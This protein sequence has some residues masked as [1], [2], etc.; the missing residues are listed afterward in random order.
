MARQRIGNVSG[1]F[2]ASCSP[3]LT[4]SSETVPRSAELPD[5]TGNVAGEGA[6]ISGMAGRYATAL[7]ELAL[8]ANSVDTVSSDLDRFAA[9]IEDRRPTR[10]NLATRPATLPVSGRDRPE[11]RPLGRCRVRVRFAPS[12]RGSHKIILKGRCP[13]V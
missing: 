5:G 7:F 13:A 1:R 6:H 8:E 12:T 11:R 3:T 2:C 9:L 10:L 4:W